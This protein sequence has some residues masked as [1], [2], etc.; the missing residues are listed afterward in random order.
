MKRAFITGITGQDGSYLA[1]LLL[2][3]GYEVHG[4]VRR[5]SSF[6]T[7]RIDHVYQDARDPDA[8]LFLH[9]GDM[10]DGVR[11][12][13]LLGAIAPDEVYNLAGQSH[14]RESFDQPRFTAEIVAMGT[15][16]LLEAIRH[17]RVACRFYQAGSS[18]M[19]GD[20]APPHTELSLLAPR[21][22]EA[23]AKAYAHWTTRNY[24][25]GYDLF[26]VNG[27]AFNHE[28]PRRGET[29]VTRKISQ[30]VARIQAGRQDFLYL[31]DLSP[32]RDWGYA[33][34]YVEGMWR[35]LQQDEPDDYVLATGTGHP[36]QDFVEAAFDHAGLDWDRHVRFDERYLR[37]TEVVELLGVPDKA[38]EKLGW[39][40]TVQMAELARIMVDADVAALE[41]E[42]RHWVD[43]VRLPTWPVLATD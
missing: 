3:K 22:P 25:E 12:L 37:P 31:G 26:A 2:L 16:H 9:H 8:R 41:H 10:T 32:V 7:G 28:S 4:L 19:F 11:L 33:P 21:S 34:E 40:A 24:R 17:S 23:T 13:T 36:V 5:A 29:F 27:I 20:S 39:R 18:D 1:E 38:A 35:T 15:L 43:D 30:A 42:G 6:N 14:V